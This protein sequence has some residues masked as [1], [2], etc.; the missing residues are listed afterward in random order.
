MPWD[1]AI[2]PLGIYLTNFVTEEQIMYAPDIII[3]AL[4]IT[5]KNLKHKD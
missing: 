3:I 2:T 4:L 1:P 5:V